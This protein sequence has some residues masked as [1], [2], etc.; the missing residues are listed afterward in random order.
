MDQFSG[1][2]TF[3]L[4]PTY[5]QFGQYAKP[6]VTR[7]AHRKSRAGCTTCR[8]KRVKCDEKH[9]ACTYCVRRKIDCS[10]E[11]SPT[12]DRRDSGQSSPDASQ[13]Y[14]EEETS[15]VLVRSERPARPF[16]AAS[17]EVLLY[18][19]YEI[20]TSNGLLVGREPGKYHKRVLT[21][22]QDVY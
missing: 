21:L 19:H 4:K 16:E 15:D 1:C 9:P 20:M 13:T 8:Q 12:A 14:C 18:N 3:V 11:S 22:S 10:Y 5:P 2:H 17:T 7:R 6:H